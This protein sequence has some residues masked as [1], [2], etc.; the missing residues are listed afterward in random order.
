MTAKVSDYKNELYS[1]EYP[2]DAPPQTD[3]LKR[4]GLAAIPFLSLHS[5]LRAPI[6]LAMGTLRVWNTDSNEIVQ[7]V[8]AVVALIGSVFQYRAGLILT[9]LHDLVLEVKKLQSLDNWEDASKSLVKIFNH[10]VYLALISRGGLE[11]SIV[12]FALQAVI[13]LMNSK[14]EFKN[15]RWIEGVANLL[16]SG[17]RLKQTYTNVQQLRRNWEIEEAIKK[18]SVGELH[19]KWRFPS[20]HLPVG[21]EVNG[22][23]IISWNVLNNAYMQWVTDKDSQGLNGSLISELDVRVNDSGLTQRDVLVADM[24]QE[25]MSKGQ[26]VALQECSVPFLAH[27]KERLP[28][29]WGMVKSFNFNRQDQDVV[30]YDR[31]QLTYRRDLSETTQYA[32]PSVPKRPLQNTY[33]SQ[34]GG[35]DLR[36]INAHIP[37][38]PNLPAREEFASYVHK[39]HQEDIITVA[40]GDNNFERDEM[41]EAYRKAGFTDFSIHSPWKTNIDPVTKESKGIDHLFVAGDHKSRDLKAEEILNE[42]LRAT[43]EL[44]NQRNA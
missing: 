6:S 2:N 21:I 7:K 28:E 31:S 25:M 36:I 22:V 35:P 40:L 1:R 16:M 38:D 3:Y 18:I 19:E 26:V 13:N 33:F 42:R 29:Q 41:I 20:D 15:G 23:K 32:Y 39:Q 8:V 27:L 17:V 30:L 12:A 5:A 37:G 43:I 11:L 9:T 10:L 34:N 4:I 44:L 14:D 24:V